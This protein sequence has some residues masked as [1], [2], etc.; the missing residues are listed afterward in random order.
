MSCF[1]ADAA[2]WAFWWS[3]LSYLSTCSGFSLPV[4]WIKPPVFCRWGTYTGF[5]ASLLAG[6]CV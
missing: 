3:V 6:T 1:L 2:L 5:T 4:Y